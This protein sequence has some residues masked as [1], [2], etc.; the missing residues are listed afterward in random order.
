MSTSVL[1]TDGYKVSMAE[2]GWPLRRETFYYAHRKGGPAVVPFD[3]ERELKQL[4]PAP[5]AADVDYLGRNQYEAGAAF[6]AAFL[7]AGEVK[8]QALPQGAAFLDREPVFSVSGPSALV[9]WLEPLVLMWNWRIQLAT[10]ALLR[11]AELP[12]LL[13]NLTCAR[14]AE[15][16]KETLDAVGVKAPPMRVDS[17]GYAERVAARGRELVEIVG[18]PAR[19]FEV[20]LRAATC[21]EQHLLALS[22]LK[23]V[24]ITRTSNIWGARELG[25]TPVG[26]MGHEHV[27]RYGSDDAAFRAMTERRPQR[28]SFLLDT[29]DT[30]GS[31][32][33]A[34][35][36]LIQ[37]RPGEKDSIRYDSG[38]KEAQYLFAAARAKELGIRPVQILEDGFDAAMT[39][40]FEVLR[41]QVG[42][43]PEEQVY[44]YGGYLVAQPMSSPLTRDKVAAVYKLTQTGHRPTMKFANEAG[45]GKQ[46]VPGRPVLFR[47]RAGAGAAGIIGQE[48]E[49]PPDGYFLLTG[50]ALEPAASLA[51]IAGGTVELSGATQALVA[52]LKA[53]AFGRAE[54]RGQGA[55]G[56][57]G[58]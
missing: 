12:A 34:A 52:E 40:R 1:M 57:H 5:T 17:A 13:E 22:A 4:F 54:G 50:A 29:F 35:F 26:T 2:A 42:W 9:S 48:G 51:K 30:M 53:R 18:D 10:A 56:G 37:E 15:L 8:V 11:P 33:P 39:R 3:V 36:A 44:G 47:R 58:S 16:A 27:Q 43:K 14:Q 21:M 20:G 49:R 23:S 46:S 24:G 6:R 32:I 19:I 38:D 41:A 31:G 25:L 28:S 7:R 55:A 45:S